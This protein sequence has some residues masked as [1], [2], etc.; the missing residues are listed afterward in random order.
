MAPQPGTRDS[1]SDRPEAL[2]SGM[3][4]GVSFLLLAGLAM[5]VI[6]AVALLPA[7][8]RLNQVT[9]EDDRIDAVNAYY[10][11][12]IDVNRR[13]IE[14]VPGDRILAKR[15]AMRRFG[16]LPRAEYVVAGTEDHSASQASAVFVEPPA[17]PQPVENWT[18][19]IAAK[20]SNPETRMILLAVA[21]AS[22]VAAVL[23]T[24]APRR[25]RKAPSA[26]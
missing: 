20:L 3:A 14:A 26:P 5:A 4:R 23:F 10:Q 7:Y 19:A 16:S 22:L 8:T 1:E 6:A 25:K 15:M 11:R 21:A 9:I 13:L 17:R 18:T 12:H 24:G 2:A